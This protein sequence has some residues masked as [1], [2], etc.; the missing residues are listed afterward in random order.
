MKNTKI[1]AI[2][3]K[4]RNEM[5]LFGLKSVTVLTSVILS[6]VLCSCST[7]SGQLSTEKTPQEAESTTERTI[8]QVQ[9]TYKL[10][11]EESTIEEA[12]TEPVK[13]DSWKQIYIDYLTGSENADYYEYAL[14]Y[15]DEDDIPELY[16]HGKQRPM[17]SEICWIYEGNVYSQRLMI[18]GFAYHEKEN[19]F[20]STGIQAGVQGDYVYSISGSETVEKAKGTA[21]RVIQGQ[22]RFTWNG[23]D[24]TESEY[25]ALRA[26]A[27]DSS[28]A[29]TVDSYDTVQDIISDFN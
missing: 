25:E 26:E 5:K 27:F 12:A 1:T 2:F 22:E 3:A 18:D 13:D 8:E 24:V 6:I 16:K 20:F 17:S 19:L 28:N 10:T 21:S 7:A 4:E 11:T 15:V 23:E 14:V 9:T 29:K